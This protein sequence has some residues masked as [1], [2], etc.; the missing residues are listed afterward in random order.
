MKAFNI[1]R[2]IYWKNLLTYLAFSA[3]A[4]IF[5]IVTVVG[6]SAV[7]A[8]P[9]VFLLSGALLY[10]ML[11][12]LLIR[13]QH[14]RSVR[15]TRSAYTV[16]IAVLG[17][18]SFLF[19]KPLNDPASVPT[20]D[21]GVRY[22]R[23]STGSSIAYVH[24]EAKGDK[25]PSPI[26]F[27][28]GG[29]G[30]P[31]MAGDVRFFSRLA[32]EG[33]DVYIYDQVGSGRSSRLN[34]P[35]DYGILRDVADLEAIRHQIGAERMILI[36]HS[37]GCE[38]IADYMAGYPDQVEKAVFSSPGAINPKDTSDAGLTGKLDEAQLRELYAN[39]LQPR[40]L[41]VYALLQVNPEA[42]H[43]LA[44]DE[45][46][47]ARFDRVYAATEPAL[48]AK[49]KRSGQ[50]IHGLGFYA[51]QFP[52]SRT[53]P[54]SPDPRQ[55]LARLNAPALILKGSDDYLSW[56]SAMDYRNA[57]RNSQL[58]YLEEAGHNLYQDQPTLARE[59]IVSF[60]AGRPLPLRPY[61]EVSPPATFRGP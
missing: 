56:S 43:R 61:E 34:D 49:G 3:V 52:Q 42:A 60:L 51:N 12:G 50:R 24:V 10:F 53:A 7:S 11:Y 16:G 28:H 25:R 6:V 47:D 35:R 45:E 18:A 4:L 55:A 36:G 54:E 26:V 20:S 1:G 30:T 37:Y 21:D 31:D 17:A 32:D 8:D 14:R 48:H 58:V 9:A 2:R 27:L 13:W 23:L 41:L 15:W 29:P 22:W 33:Y 5:G 39:L 57:L 46:M 44:G 38:I 59:L 19:L 40:A